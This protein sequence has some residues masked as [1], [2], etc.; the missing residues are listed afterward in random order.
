MVDEVY[1]NTTT[2]PFYLRGRK[3]PVSTK[4]MGASFTPCYRCVC[5]SVPIT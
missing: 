5:C 4:R 1:G 2:T 3:D